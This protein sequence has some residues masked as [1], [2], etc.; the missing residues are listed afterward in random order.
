[1]TAH[2]LAAKLLSMPDIEVCLSLYTGGNDEITSIED[3]NIVSDDYLGD[4]IV[5]QVYKEQ[6]C[7]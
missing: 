3:A 4:V 5:V 6:S 2:E 1:M 7:E